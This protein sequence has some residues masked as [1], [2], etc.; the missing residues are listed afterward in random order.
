MD[1]GNERTLLVL[2][3]NK[4][5]IHRARKQERHLAESNANCPRFDCVSNGNYVYRRPHLDHF[6]ARIFD[7]FDIGVWSSM[8][9]FNTDIIVTEVFG[10]YRKDLKFVL[11]RTHCSD[12]RNGADHSST[13][14]LSILWNNG[15]RWSSV[16]RIICIWLLS[17]A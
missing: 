11:D 14:D 4:T 12:V 6:F 15:S 16:R 17:T 1:K 2:D 3:I 8:I 10:G 13:K 5:L 7:L 9:P